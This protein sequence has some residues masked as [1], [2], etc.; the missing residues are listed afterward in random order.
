MLVL[1]D[2]I[3]ITQE[4]NDFRNAAL[5][6]VNAF[7]VTA[8]APGITNQRKLEVSQ[9]IEDI[10]AGF[11]QG[12]ISSNMAYLEQMKAS[13][14]HYFNQR[15]SQATMLRMQGRVEDAASIE[16]DI[17][18]SLQVREK[19]YANM[20]AQAKAEGPQR[21]KDKYESRINTAEITAFKADLKSLTDQATQWARDLSLIHI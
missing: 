5:E 1:P 2:A 13:S 4:L 17:A 10:K 20:V 7:L 3:G 16:A 15:R 11:E 18:R 21:W 19:N 14:D 9:A 8:S 6:P 12:V